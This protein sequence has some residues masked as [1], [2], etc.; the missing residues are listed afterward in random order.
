MGC[1]VIPSLQIDAVVFPV[2]LA[3]DGTTMD[4]TQD[5]WTVGWWNGGTGGVVPGRAGDSVMT[6]HN[7]WYSGDALCQNLYTIA[8][9]AVVDV[10]LKDG[11]THRFKVDTVQ[12]V[13]SDATVPGLF[14][15]TG[16]A[17]LSIITCGGNWDNKTQNYSLRVIVNAH[18]A[19]VPA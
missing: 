13:A 17:R 5:A 12:T 7:H 11:S 18:L 4:V 9:G 6:C 2:G 1:I 19:S 14:D 16:P 3:K 15:A 8:A 10:V